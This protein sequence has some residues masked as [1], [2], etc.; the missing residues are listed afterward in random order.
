MQIIV[1]KEIA[2]PDHFVIFRKKSEKSFACLPPARNLA[3]RLRGE[4]TIFYH[5]AASAFEIHFTISSYQT[6][7]HV[8]R[9]KLL[10]ERRRKNTKKTQIKIGEREKLYVQAK[11]RD[12]NVSADNAKRQSRNLI[13]F[14]TRKS[15]ATPVSGLINIL[16]ATHQG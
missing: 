13:Q 6:H 8:P 2:D 1:I 14:L 3:R 9:R 11:S 7:T 10:L 5:R 15:I 4:K 12:R 16:I